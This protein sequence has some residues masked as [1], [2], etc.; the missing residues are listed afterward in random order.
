MVVAMTM[1]NLVPIHSSMPELSFPILDR[2]GA[3]EEMGAESMGMAKSITVLP[4]WDVDML[5]NTINMNE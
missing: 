4:C 5:S 2:G 1:T 3:Q